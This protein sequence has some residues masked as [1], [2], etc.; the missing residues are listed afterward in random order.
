D[1]I[2]QARWFTRDEVATVLAG[3]RVDAGDGARVV[4]PPASSI[5]LFLIERWL[6][7]G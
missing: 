2:A 1:E 5:A 3:D 7:A 6:S 4:L